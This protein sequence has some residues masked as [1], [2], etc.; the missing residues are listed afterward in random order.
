[1]ESGRKSPGRW[2]AVNTFSFACITGKLA[3]LH[4]SASRRGIIFNDMNEWMDERPWTLFLEVKSNFSARLSRTLLQRFDTDWLVCLV[5]I[6]LK[7]K[8]S[9]RKIKLRPYKN[10][11]HCRRTT[12]FCAVSPFGL[13]S[14][15]TTWFI[16]KHKTISWLNYQQESPRRWRGKARIW[17]CPQFITLHPVGSLESLSSEFHVFECVTQS[18]WNGSWSWWMSGVT[19]KTIRSA[20]SLK[21]NFLNHLFR[22]IDGKD[23]AW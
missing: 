23:T 17:G 2:R 18:I 4:K 5:S 11:H 19:L 20:E 6:S 15:G 14:P 13:I 22:E 1:M 9:E 3:I 12:F 7:W 16:N 8:W 21:N 10:S